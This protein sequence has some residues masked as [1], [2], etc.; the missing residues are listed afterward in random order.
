MKILIAYDGSSCA[1]HAL[2]D[3]SRA[4][5]PER[6]EAMVVSVAESRLPN[7]PPSSYEILES[8]FVEGA[9]IGFESLA[10]SR[11]VEEAYAL[12][13]QASKRV[14]ASFPGWDVRANGYSG[15]PAGQIVE[16]AENWGADLVVVGSHGR[17]ALG[18]LMLGS[19]AQRVVT[20]A[21]C[22]VRVARAPRGER[23]SPLRILIGV[24]GSSHSGA[25]VMEVASRSWPKGSEVRLLTSVD[26]WSEYAAEPD[27][28][29]AGVRGIHQSA[30][31]F[32]R[33]AGLEVSSQVK[34]EDAKHLLV[35]EAESWGA[36][37]IF[38]GARGLGRLGRMLLGSVS[39]AV[40]ARA[41][42]S[43]EVVRLS[44]AE[45]PQSSE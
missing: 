43:V 34:E 24:D 16:K 12:A 37:S 22:S 36:D 35:N 23:D 38:V 28:K 31:A 5:L 17:S 3:L 8:A 30:E 20:D 2:D 7:P 29:Y 13:F 44:K 41:H 4:G 10:T 45:E 15:S 25:A 14:Q 26:P 21:H 18:R 32:L 33:A 9:D 27:D 42:C 6:T 19:V 40:V 11:I 1:D 39:T